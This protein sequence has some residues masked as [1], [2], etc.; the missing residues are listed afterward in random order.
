MP[1]LPW[2]LPWYFSIF[3]FKIFFSSFNTLVTALQHWFK[4][5]FYCSLFYGI[6]SSVRVVA[7][8]M[9]EMSLEKHPF[10][11]NFN[12]GNREESHGAKSGEIFT[13]RWKFA[14]CE[15]QEYFYK[16]S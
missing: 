12:F 11:F 15:T 3:L 6:D 8:F 16:C 5:V 9:I 14:T 2:L 1:W 7:V 10:N 4:C 13:K